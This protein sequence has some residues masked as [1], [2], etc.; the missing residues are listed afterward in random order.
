MF[1]R[2]IDTSGEQSTPLTRT[3]IPDSTTPSNPPRQPPPA[4]DSIKVQYHKATGRSPEI[5]AFEDF[6]RDQHHINSVPVNQEPWKPAFN[7]RLDFEL[8]ELAHEVHMNK[9]QVQRL[10]N[11][12]H[13]V[14]AGKD[15]FTFVR[16]DDVDHAWSKLYPSVRFQPLPCH[17]TI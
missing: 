17:S 1:M 4:V 6:T 2:A 10:L 12:I 14:A 5:Y 7:S 9:G 13:D 3:T 8:A 15:R 16:V 11:I